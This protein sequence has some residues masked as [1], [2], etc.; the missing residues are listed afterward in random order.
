M[1][2]DIRIRLV[3]L[4]ASGSIDPQAAALLI[5]SSAMTKSRHRSSK[6]ERDSWRSSATC[7]FHPSIFRRFGI[8]GAAAIGR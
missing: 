3:L 8:A 2:I 1:H 6:S 7:F 4:R 5:S